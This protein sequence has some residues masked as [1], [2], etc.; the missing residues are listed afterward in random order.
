MTTPIQ[1]AGEAL[2]A[3]NQAFTLF[4][5]IAAALDLGNPKARASRLRRRAVDK[6]RAAA[7]ARKQRRRT[8]LL[9]DAAALE[10]KAAILDPASAAPAP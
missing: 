7:K 6:R 8:N 4:E 2:S 9:A 5:R 10:A 1:R 3:A